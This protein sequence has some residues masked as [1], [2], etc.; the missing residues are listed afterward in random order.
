[1]LFIYNNDELPP[2]SSEKYWLS[3]DGRYSVYSHATYP[4]VAAKD[5]N[6]LGIFSVTKYIMRL[7]IFPLP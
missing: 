6:E 4:P 7:Q 5:N 3:G 2:I 1:M